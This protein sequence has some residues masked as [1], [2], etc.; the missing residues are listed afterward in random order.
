MARK[1]DSFPVGSSLRYEY[2]F[3]STTQL[4]IT[5]VGYSRRPKQ[6][7]AVR[8]LGRNAPYHF[9]CS[10][11]GKEAAYLCCECQWTQDNPFL[12]EDCAREHEH[13]SMLPVVN[14]PR[15]GVCA[16][17]GEMDIYEFEPD[18]TDWASR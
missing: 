1:I 15:M 13:G 16:Y 6:Q 7:K 12:C 9:S 2:D 3:G 14:S 11:C 5:I 4:K 8:L 18:K 17:C 10:V